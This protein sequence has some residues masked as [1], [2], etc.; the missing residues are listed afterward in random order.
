[1]VNKLNWRTTVSN[2]DRVLYLR[3]MRD[4]KDY[5]RK[6]YID[7]VVLLVNF[8]S[9]PQ[10]FVRRCYAQ[11][12]QPKPA[13]VYILNWKVPDDVHLVMKEL[14]TFIC[15][16]NH[17]SFDVNGYKEAY[18]EFIQYCKKKT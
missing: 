17:V 10:T 13:D 6:G 1:M 12:P 3:I 9:L 18:D 16:L 14:I 7:T 4:V 15:Q 5:C 2:D 8:I 11:A